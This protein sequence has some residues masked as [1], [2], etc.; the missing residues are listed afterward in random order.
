MKFAASFF[1]CVLL[2]GHLHFSLCLL[3]PLSLLAHALSHALTPFLSHSCSSTGSKPVPVQGRFEL[4]GVFVCA[5]VFKHSLKFLF[6]FHFYNFSDIILFYPMIPAFLLNPRPRVYCQARYILEFNR[7][8]VAS[9][10]SV[11][12]RLFF[13]LADPEDSFTPRGQQSRQEQP[14]RQGGHL[15]LPLPLFL[16]PSLPL[17]LVLYT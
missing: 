2:F 9:K 11:F 14:R 3:S 17:P 10:S 7:Y 15:S 8:L 6:P 13:S 12:T 16:S 4:C 1:L 5:C